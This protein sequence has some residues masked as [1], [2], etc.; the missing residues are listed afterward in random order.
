ML[1]YEHILLIIKEQNK[2]A[3]HHF[4]SQHCKRTE[5]PDQEIEKQEKIKDIKIGEK[6]IFI[7]CRQYLC[8]PSTTPPKST[9]KLLKLIN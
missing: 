8:P 6:K 4:Y 9:N 3:Y 7:I 1:K 2:Y 5:K